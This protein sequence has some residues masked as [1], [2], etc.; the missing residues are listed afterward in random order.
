M[1]LKNAQNLKI[2]R[3]INKKLKNK[4]STINHNLKVKT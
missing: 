2:F 1:K 3:I 4:I